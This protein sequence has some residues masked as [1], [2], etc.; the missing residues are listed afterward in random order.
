MILCIARSSN[1][2]TAVSGTVNR[3]STPC[4]ATFMKEIN[5]NNQGLLLVYAH[6]APDIWRKLATIE[7]TGWVMHG[8]KNPETIQ[9]HTID[10][11]KLA[12]SLSVLLELSEIDNKDL[13]NMLEIH[14]WVE[15]FV[16]DIVVL[17]DGSDEY[18]TKKEN[19]KKAESKAINIIKKQLG[20]KGLEIYN[21]WQRFETS[22][23]T[24]ATLA[25]EIDKYQALEKALYYEKS[26]GIKV[27][28]EFYNYSIKYISHP[29]LLKRAKMLLEESQQIS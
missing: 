3:G 28:E 5:E 18:K 27:F 22:N 25:R 2:R 20:K 8:I 1:G 16:G 10:C 12:M 29:A 17:D 6:Y 13:V 9:D 15:A 14:D 21:L 26:Q 23:D 11:I 24:I 4:L 7:R 19:K